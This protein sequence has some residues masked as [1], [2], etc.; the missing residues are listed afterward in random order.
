MSFLTG[1]INYA[2][3]YLLTLMSLV[4]GDMVR[5]LWPRCIGRPIDDDTT[6]DDLAEWQ[7]LPNTFD[8][9][10]ETM[11]V[12]NAG[13]D[14]SGANR[15]RLVYSRRTSDIGEDNTLYEVCLRLQGT[16][17]NS[18]IGPLG[19]WNGYV[20]VLDDMSIDE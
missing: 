3:L 10:C 20:V 17:C 16:V 9:M 14:S 11:E 15:H 13:R 18:K 19:D 7:I 8:G 6:M 5:D 12:T 4:N 2:A 1:K